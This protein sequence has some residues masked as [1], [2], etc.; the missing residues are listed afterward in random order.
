MSDSSKVCLV[1]GG[2]GGLG[3]G[4][5]LDLA[6]TGWKTIVAGRNQTKGDEIVKEIT[7]SGGTA[8]F[9]PVDITSPSSISDLHEKAVST[10][11]RLDAAINSAGT[12][13]DVVK[14]ADSSPENTAAVL[15]INLHGVILSMQHQIRAMQSNP[16]GSGGR[17]INMSSVYGS[18]GGIWASIYSGTKHALEGITK[19]VA[20]EYSNPK[21]NVLVNCI[22]PGVIVTEMT[23]VIADP[24]VLPDGELKEYCMGLRKQYAQERYGEVSDIARGVRY[25]L[26]S[27]WVT[28]TTLQIEGGF[29]A[30]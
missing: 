16:S 29:G 6:S 20:L 24:S 1:I 13:G 12:T 7:S 8:T 11:G 25:L 3:R 26:E 5:A 28:G 18:H 14:F 23:A 30:R 21:D 10:Y 9:L 27:P 15:S 19:S 2:T 17:I 22:A 4:I